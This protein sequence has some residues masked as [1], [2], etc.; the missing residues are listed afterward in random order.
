MTQD[1]LARIVGSART[2]AVVGM[3]DEGSPGAP[4]FYVPEA[5]QRAGIRVIP[6]NP[7]IEASLGEPA[8]DS[9]SQVDE[10]VDVVVVFRRSDAVPAVADD[11]LALPSERRP[12]VVWMQTGII[13]EDAATRLRAAGIQVVMDRCFKV[14]LARAGRGM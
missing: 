7:T 3:K 2:A 8:R 12:K 14:E 1:D 6:V 9:L 11:V 5:M 13:H 4:A 10:P